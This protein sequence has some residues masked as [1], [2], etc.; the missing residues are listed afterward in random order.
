MRE[1]QNFYSAAFCIGLATLIFSTM[2]VVLKPPRW[3][4]PTPCR[5]PWAASWWAA[6]A[7]SPWP[8]WALTGR[9]T[10]LTGKDLRSFALT[11]FFCVPLAMVLYQLALTTAT[12]TWWR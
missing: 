9:E 1:K 2:E 6:S 11:G 10:K 7:C 4:G 12:P 3:R 8:G 5:S